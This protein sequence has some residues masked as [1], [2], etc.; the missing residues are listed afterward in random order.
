MM[1]VFIFLLQF[2]VAVSL[3]R[4][5]KHP[6]AQNSMKRSAATES[7]N[8]LVSLGAGSFAGAIGIG[9]AYPFDAL[10]TKAQ[11]YAASSSSE[12]LSLPKLAKKLLESEGIGGFYGGVRGV[13]AVSDVENSLESY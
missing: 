4:S 8:T 10:K 6:S 2:S 3:L 13:M 5:S 11:I 12:R 1:R 9:T 7:L